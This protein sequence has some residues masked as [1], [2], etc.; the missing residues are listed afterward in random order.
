MVSDNKSSEV[1]TCNQ[2]IGWRNNPDAIKHFILPDGAGPIEP[3]KAEKVVK[4]WSKN[5]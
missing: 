4:E 5:W 2:F 3:K 1:F